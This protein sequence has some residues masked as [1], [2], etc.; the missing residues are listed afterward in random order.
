[1]LEGLVQQLGRVVVSREPQRGTCPFV[2]S[3]AGFFAGVLAGL[4]AA[5]RT[6]LFGVVFVVVVVFLAMGLLELPHEI[7]Q[8]LHAGLR[9]RVVERGAHAAEHAVALQRH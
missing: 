4:S 6:A 7:D 1:M 2:Q 3:F 9:H 8:C 5:F